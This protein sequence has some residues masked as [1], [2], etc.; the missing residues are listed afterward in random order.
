MNSYSAGK[1]VK[2][3]STKIYL[4][5]SKFQ[6]EGDFEPRCDGKE[7]EYL[8]K[9]KLRRIRIER[10]NVKRGREQELEILRQ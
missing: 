3:N 2:A 5:T 6:I 10:H 1:A 9:P 4:G 7:L 8:A